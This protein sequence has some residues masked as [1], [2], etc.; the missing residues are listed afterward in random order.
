MNYQDWCSFCDS[1]KESGRVIERPEVPTDDFTKALGYRDD[2]ICNEETR[3][4]V[5]EII[6]DIADRTKDDIAEY[7][8]VKLTQPLREDEDLLTSL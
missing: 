7:L 4:K 8:W 2:V 6:A 1:L 5:A 3:A